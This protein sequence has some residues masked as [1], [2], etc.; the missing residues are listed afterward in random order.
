ML[1]VGRNVSGDFP[2]LLRIIL[3][4]LFFLFYNK[5]MIRYDKIC[6]ISIDSKRYDSLMS[7]FPNSS[8]SLIVRFLIDFYFH[9]LEEIKD[10]K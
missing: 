6:S 7:L 1:S 4:F 3:A 10:E 9:H 2:S 8:F 5:F